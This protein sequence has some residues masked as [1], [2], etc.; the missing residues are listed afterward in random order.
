MADKLAPDAILLDFRMPGLNGF[1]AATQILQRS[2]SLPIILYSLN[3]ISTLEK[4]AKEI[5]IAK[6]ISKVDVF[7]SLIGSL[8]EAVPGTPAAPVISMA[9]TQTC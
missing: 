4:H 9:R 3:E 2:P 8:E 7:T 6:V 5:G 1:E